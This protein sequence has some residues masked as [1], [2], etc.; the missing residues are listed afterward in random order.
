MNENLKAFLEKVSKD[1]DLT[2]KVS[3]ITETTD[4]IA[5]AAE[6][7]YELKAVDFEV[8]EGEMS[9]SELS[10]VSGGRCFCT[11]YGG[12]GGTDARDDNTYGCACFVYGQGGDGRADDA[13]CICVQAGGGDDTAQYM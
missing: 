6:Y 10:D 2:E 1:K 12:G 8:I 9:E 3:S 7:G 13:N 4:F 5:V 11:M